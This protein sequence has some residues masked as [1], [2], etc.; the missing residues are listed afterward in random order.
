MEHRNTLRRQGRRAAPVHGR[1]VQME[2]GVEWRHQFGALL[3]HD[4][5][6]RECARDAA[7][8]AALR[9]AP[10]TQTN[11]VDRVAMHRQFAAPAIGPLIA[12]L[13]PVYHVAEIV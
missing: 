4:V 13:A 7:F 2:S 9:L 8:A 1:T 10:T 11:D 12:I 3:E 5:V 6:E